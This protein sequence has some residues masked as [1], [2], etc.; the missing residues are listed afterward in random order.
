M[1]LDDD[2]DSGSHSILARITTVLL[3]LLVQA[4]AVLVVGL[5]ALFLNIVPGWSAEGPPA[6]LTKPSDARSGSLLLKS[7]DGY[8]DAPRLGIDVDITVSGPTARA[9]VTQVFRNPTDHWMEATYVYPLPAGGAVDTLKTAITSWSATSRH[10]SR[11]ELSTTM[12]SATARPP[13]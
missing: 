11:H 9:R 13:R 4:G 7:D 3:F 12:P 8:S 10:V 2:M 5:T 1:T 6:A